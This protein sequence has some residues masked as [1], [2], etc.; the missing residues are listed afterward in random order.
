MGVEGVDHTKQDRHV[1]DIAFLEHLDVVN[2]KA[3][4]FGELLDA[5]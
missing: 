3:S 4:T 1:G 2:G 5:E